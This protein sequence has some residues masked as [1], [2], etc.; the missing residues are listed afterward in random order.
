MDNNRARKSVFRPVVMSSTSPSRPRATL[1]VV[2]IPTG[3]VASTHKR[4]AAL[5]VDSLI[6]I[7][8]F[9]ACCGKDLHQLFETV[10]QPQGAPFLIP[11]IC[12]SILPAHVFFYKW[13][14][15]TP[16]KLLL[17]LKVISART[18]D[19]D[20]TWT[21]AIV[22]TVIP[23]FNFMLGS[24]P[25]ILALTSQERRTLWDLIAGTRVVQANMRKSPVKRRW[26]FASIL[27]IEAVWTLLTH[28]PTDSLKRWKLTP[29][30]VLL[31]P[32]AHT[33]STSS[34][35]NQ[36]RSTACISRN[37]PRVVNFSSDIDSK[38]QKEY[39]NVRA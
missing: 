16:G 32:Y 24:L 8:F 23:Y 39:E 26:I 37:A 20:L 30:G 1:K 36:Y 3:D 31:L 13:K 14:G 29:E 6:H 21:Q 28:T 18:E 12:W 27:A 9:L 7:S 22:R 25:Y 11:W 15:A 2:N 4:I 34:A 33:E 10:T 17:G 5:L 35:V 38:C 19:P